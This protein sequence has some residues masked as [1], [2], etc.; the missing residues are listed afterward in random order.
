M[1]LK[2]GI[3]GLSGIGNNHANWYAQDDLAELVA[4]CDLMKEK[5]DILPK[6]LGQKLIITFKIW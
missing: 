3:V 6:S 4:V 5:A 1:A 2:V